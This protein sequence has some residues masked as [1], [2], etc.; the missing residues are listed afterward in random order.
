MKHIKFLILATAS[1]FMVTLCCL[2]VLLFV[3]FGTSF[4]FLSFLEPLSEFRLIF[5]MFSL[6]CFALSIFFIFF[7][8]NTCAVGQR[9]KR[10]IFIY[11]L[12]AFLMIILLA[13]PEI[14]GEFYA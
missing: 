5:T 11:L 6:I 2:P 3:L 8:Q 7:N 9:R 14:L 4:S 13:Y 10:W 1:A 12:F